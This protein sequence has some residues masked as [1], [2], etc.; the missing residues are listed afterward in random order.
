M[1]RF[2]LL[3]IILIFAI[4]ELHAFNIQKSIRLETV[5]QKESLSET[6]DGS[7]FLTLP[8]G[9]AFISNQDIHSVSLT[10]KG[11]NRTTLHYHNDQH[12]SEMN[13]PNSHN[14]KHSHRLNNLFHLHNASLSALDVTFDL[15]S[16]SSNGAVMC[17]SLTSSSVHITNCG[18]YWTGTHSI[19]VLQGSSLSPQ[20]S[21]SIT[22]VGC[23]LDNSKQHLAPIV[24]DIR[25]GGGSELFSLD[26]VV[27]RIA[28]TRVIGTDGIGV[29][30]PSQNGIW[31][32]LEG[33]CTTFSEMSF[34]NVS[35]LPGTVRQVSGLFSQRMVGCAIWGSNNHL[36]GSTLRDMNGGGG[37]LCSN[38]SFNWCLTTSSERPSLSPHTPLSSSLAPTN[39]PDSPAEPGDNETDRFTGKVY[40]NVDRFNFTEETVTF[41]R[42]WFF[43]MKYSITSSLQ[44]FAGGSALFF[45]SN[46]TALNL[47]LCE[48]EN[49]SVTS[50]FPHIIIYAGCVY[51]YSNT[52]SVITPP[53]ATI[54]SCSFKDWYPSSNNTHQFGGCVGT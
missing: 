52:G 15:H 7:Q 26:I 48:F 38:S 32:H 42:C 21:S 25:G 19:F 51:L 36:S 16:E 9:G 30:Q 47:T 20:T 43:N 22:L 27:T 13:T 3:H 46:T 34:S 39:T 54:D 23:T 50:S 4:P 37:F 8:N 29:A 24:E 6:L 40:N 45:H 28:N 5:L 1:I 49:C 2:Y 17:A 10:L 33:I 44:M 12:K 41:N 18:F 53:V 31:S 11:Q 35:S 14:T